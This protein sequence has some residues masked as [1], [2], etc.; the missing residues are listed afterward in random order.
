MNP[1]LPP[2][3]KS[4]NHI[5][6]VHTSMESQHAA[7]EAAAY[8]NGYTIAL[9]TLLDD[10]NSH[11]NFINNFNQVGSQFSPSMKNVI[12]LLATGEPFPKSVQLAWSTPR[13]D[14]VME[15]LHNVCAKQEE[16]IILGL[17]NG[18]PLEVTLQGYVLC[19]GL[20]ERDL[21]GEGIMTLKKD[22]QKMELVIHVLGTVSATGTAVLLDENENVWLYNPPDT[23]DRQLPNFP[24][25][26]ILALRKGEIAGMERIL[27]LDDVY[28][29]EVVVDESESEDE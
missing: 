2:N 25:K 16:T 23:I 21:R 3:L 12:S 29:A 7:A 24:R 5:L 8:R 9:K 4:S 10:C 14:D 6:K 28:D 26:A 20:G 17:L 18:K 19:Q 13:F 22:D 11:L 27:I 15:Y 1:P